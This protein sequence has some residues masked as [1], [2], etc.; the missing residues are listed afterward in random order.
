MVHVSMV[1]HATKD[2]SHKE[3]Q[4]AQEAQNSLDYFRVSCAFLWLNDRFQDPTFRNS[5]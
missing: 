3:A 4:K 5:R 2:L 1:V